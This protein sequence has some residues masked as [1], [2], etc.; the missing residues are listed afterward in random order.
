MDEL[1]IKPE[2]IK[3]KK[4][5]G[6]IRGK[7]VFAL[8]TRGGLHVVAASG[9]PPL[10]LAPHPYVARFMAKKRNPD[11]EI[12][13]LSKSEWM[14]ESAFADILKYWEGVTEHAASISR[15]R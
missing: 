2:E 10:A 13:E 12:T 7:P 5:I 4:Q 14:P 3:S 8:A 1:K 11:L 15:V 6:K 9:M